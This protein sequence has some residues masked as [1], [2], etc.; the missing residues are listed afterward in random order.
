[1]LASCGND[2][3]IRLWDPGTGAQIDGTGWPARNRSPEKQLPDRPR[4]DT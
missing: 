1:M 4:K 2:H 3:T